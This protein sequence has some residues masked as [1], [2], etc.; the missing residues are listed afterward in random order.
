MAILKHTIDDVV[1]VIGPLREFYEQGPDGKFHLSMDND[2]KLGEFRQNNVNLMRERDALKAQADADKT[3]LAELLV[4]PDNSK[5]A[6][7]LEAQLAAERSAHAA[8]Q[9]KHIV[10]T[11][12]LRVGG[13]ASAVEFVAVE[14]AKVF[15]ME[16]GKVMTVTAKEFSPTNPAEPLSIEEWM[17]KQ[18]TE[19][20]YVF[21]P[22]RGGG[23][24][25][26]N[27]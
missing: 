10:T 21:Q 16:D 9:L 22:S 1:E 24:S 14:A 8:T 7:D 3:K 26:R 2:P 17:Q 25:P 11:E 6:A 12:F 23:A 13:R 18:M 27:E 19:K 4:K 20:D 5:Q 15:A